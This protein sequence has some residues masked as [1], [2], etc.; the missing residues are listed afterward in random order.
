MKFY[1]PFMLALVFNYS[2]ITFA[3]SIAP[4]TFN[5]TGGTAVIA[6]N[7]YEFSIAEMVLVNTVTTGNLTVTQGVLQNS[8]LAPNGLKEQNLESSLLSIYPNPTENYIQLQP[9]F[10]ANTKLNFLIYDLVG[11]LMIQREVLLKRGN[12]LEQL[13]F[14][15]FVA[16]TYYL[17]VEVQDEANFYREVY[18]IVKL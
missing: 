12:E 2:N 4:A 6:G 17:T 13:D 7:T 9:N 11:K 5:S 10:K 8:P 14:S 16:G 18:K 3:Q 15:S 1:I